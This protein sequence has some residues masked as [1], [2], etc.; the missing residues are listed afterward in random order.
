MKIRGLAVPFDAPT[1]I[2]GEFMEYFDRNAFND[3]D[4]Y[5]DIPLLI[6]H[7]KDTVPIA[8]YRPGNP[9]STA[10]VWVAADGVRFEAD[11]TRRDVYEA[12]KRG[13]FTG[14]SIAFA[15]VD[16][17][18]DS[19]WNLCSSPPVVCRLRAV[20]GEISLVTFPAYKGAY[21]ETME[22]GV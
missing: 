3:L 14:V 20:I 2:G 9:H 15:Q 21:V 11:I 7:K 4:D 13:D 5:G 8:R 17:E 18:R 6:G 19:H 10:R 22:G 16:K 1:N 12:I